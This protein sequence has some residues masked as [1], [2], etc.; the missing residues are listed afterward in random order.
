MSYHKKSK[1]PYVDWRV[2]HAIDV[3]LD[4]EV[5]LVVLPRTIQLTAVVAAPT[6]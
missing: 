3:L 5:D 1:Q 2:S 6:V 4:T